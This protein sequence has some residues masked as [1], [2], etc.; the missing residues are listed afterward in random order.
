LQ[1]ICWKDITIRE[2]YNASEWFIATQMSKKDEDMLLLTKQWIFFEFI[3]MDTFHNET[4]KVY[5]LDQVE[6]NKNYAL[7]ITTLSGLYRYV[8]GDTIRFTNTNPHKIQIT[9][10]TKTYIATFGEN[11]LVD[12]TDRAIQKACEEHKVQIVEYTV[13]P[14]LFYNQKSMW[15]HER[16]IEFKKSPKDIRSFTQ[17][18][19]TTMKSVNDYYDRRR[20]NDAIIGMPIVRVMKSGTFYKRL[21]SKGKLWH[22]NKIPRLSNT[23]DFVEELEQYYK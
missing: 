20:Q 13:A 8:I 10:R 11:V 12:H 17:T 22:Q 21:K 19:D 16:H 1:D 3:D 15:A 6:V 23:R 18:L 5:T 2:V 9:W 4:P 7:V 14:I